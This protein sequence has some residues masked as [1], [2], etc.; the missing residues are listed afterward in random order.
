MGIQIWLYIIIACNGPE[1]ALPG[2]RRHNFQCIWCLHLK[3]CIKRWT[4]QYN[5]LFSIG[6]LF[7]YLFPAHSTMLLT[8]QGYR[9]SSRKRNCDW[10]TGRY[11]LVQESGHI[12]ITNNRPTLGGEGENN[13]KSQAVHYSSSDPHLTPTLT[14]STKL[15]GSAA[16]HTRLHYLLTDNL[17]VSVFLLKLASFAVQVFSPNKYICT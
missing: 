6:L 10:C 16:R 4:Q 5:L 9:A 7:V 3:V 11:I 14:I 12:L 13:Q 2:F 1:S 8:A 15:F 17:W